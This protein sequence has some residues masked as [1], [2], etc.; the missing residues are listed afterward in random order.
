MLIAVMPMISM[1]N[2][3]KS[4]GDAAYA[5]GD[6]YIKYAE[7]NPTVTE[8]KQ[9]LQ[10]DIKTYGK[11]VHLDWIELL[12]YAA[13]KTGGEFYGENNEHI[14]KAAS[15]LLNGVSIDELTSGLEYYNYYYEVY[16]AVL[17]DFVGEY[18]IEVQDEACAGGKR[19]ESKYGLK[20]F[21]PIA[22][23][24]SFTHYE[25]FGQKRS[26]G[27]ER[28]HLG[29]DILGATGTPVVAV[30]GGVVEAIGWNQYGGWRVGI[31]S[32]DGRRYYYYAHLRKDHP[33]HKSIDEG[34]IVAAGD[35]IGYIGQ[36]GY[37]TTENTNNIETPHLHFGLQLIFDESQKDGDN[38]I[39]I[40]VY[41]LVELLSSCKSA[42][43]QDEVTL[44][45]NR[46]Y[47]IIDAPHISEAVSADAEE[48]SIPIIMYHSILK[49]RN[50][51]GDYVL[52]PD[53]LESDLLWLSKNGYQTIN[54]QDIVDYVHY[55]GDLPDKPVMLT[56]D[57]GYYNNYVYAY[58]LL[59]KYG[60]KAVLSAVGEFADRFSDTEDKSISYSHMNWDELRM[61]SD[62]GIFEIQNHSYGMHY[63]ENRKGSS[64][65]KGETLEAYKESFYGD[66]MLM[67]S[68]LTENCNITPLCYTYP[69]GAIS[70][71]SVPILKEMGFMASLSCYELT[72]TVVRGDESC[73]FGLGRYNRPSGITTEEFMKK[74]LQ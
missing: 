27:Y 64:R 35:V 60:F 26:Y 37:S 40:D 68:L 71:D 20:V 2:E 23:G 25:D 34:S 70:E 18:K 69:Y 7:F 50:L 22:K 74:L 65:N 57:D 45:Y 12:A 43:S 72:S 15:S 46:I 33:Y 39:W 63:I 10:Y 52:S 4:A 42:V 49:D 8:L 54:I 32:F 24:Y 1:I 67:Q 16:S 59:E 56:F 47:N 41:D 29:N 58:P 38:Q 28:E 6:G 44:D 30:E 36:T 51:L 48:K 66:T 61:I 21:S 19:F 31:R 5:S 73:L 9:A 3:M 11:E 55:E 14:V 62:S 13:A 53:E 17:K